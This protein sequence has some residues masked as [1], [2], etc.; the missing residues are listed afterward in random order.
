M[1]RNSRVGTGGV[2]EDVC[3]FRDF[4]HPGCMLHVCLP[5][6]VAAAGWDVVSRRLLRSYL[7]IL[8]AACD[9][10]LLIYWRNDTVCFGTDARFGRFASSGVYVTMK[11]IHRALIQTLNH[12][13]HKQYV[14]GQHRAA[15]YKGALGH[16]Q[17]TLA[18]W[19]NWPLVCVYSGFCIN[20]PA[21]RSHC[22]PVI[23]P[24]P[25]PPPSVFFRKAP[26]PSP[27][28]P[29]DGTTAAFLEEEEKKKGFHTLRFSA[30]FCILSALQ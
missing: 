24:P 30:L 9:S 16:L 2:M 7:E 10:I 29:G 11:R 19:V 28:D 22:L 4:L 8:K 20:V 26:P 12:S 3:L 25:P 5:R 27:R 6:R 1:H 21:P 13:Q 15:V 23:H 17:P 14:R 18:K